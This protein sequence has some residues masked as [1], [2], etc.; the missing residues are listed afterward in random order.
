MIRQ[1]DPKILAWI[2][3]ELERILAFLNI[4]LGGDSSQRT[5]NAPCSISW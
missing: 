1:M 3:D 2:E 4:T 5:C